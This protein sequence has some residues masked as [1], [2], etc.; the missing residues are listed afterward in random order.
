MPTSTTI[1]VQTTETTVV[2]GMTVTTQV[3]SMEVVADTAA[4]TVA[5][6][7]TGSGMSGHSSNSNN[8]FTPDGAIIGAIVG[9][10]AALVLLAFGFAF[11]LSVTFLQPRLLTTDNNITH[12]GERRNTLMTNLKKTFSPTRQ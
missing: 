9:G 12:A 8:N 4:T 3:T 5:S 11:F 1:E 6:V 7:P 10:I 2:G